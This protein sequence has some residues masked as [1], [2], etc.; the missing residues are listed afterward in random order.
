MTTVILGGGASGRTILEILQDV[1]TKIGIDQPSQVFGSSDRTAIELSEAAIEAA[2]KIARAHDWAVLYT[3]ETHTGDGSTTEFAMPSD[4]ERMPKNAQVWST[5]LQHPLQHITPEDWLQMDVRGY[6]VA[7]GAWTA[8][9]GNIVYRPA[10]ASGETAKFWYISNQCV[11]NSSGTAKQRFTADD[12]V[13]RLDDRVLELTIIWV[14]REQKGLDYA[15]DMTNAEQ[16]VAR[17]I[18]D[19]KG[20]RIISQQSRRNIGAATAYPLAVTS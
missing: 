19:D 17:K 16:A 5:R 11:Q 1:A 13:F 3:L 10:L 2:D 12:D 18:S 7:L 8:Y 6:D 14:W 9:G 20:A 15:E 4:C